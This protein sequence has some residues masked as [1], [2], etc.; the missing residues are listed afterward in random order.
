MDS[1]CNNL[2]I[3][4]RNTHKIGENMRKAQNMDN[5]MPF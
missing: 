5:D 3:F 2:L 4:I 1:I